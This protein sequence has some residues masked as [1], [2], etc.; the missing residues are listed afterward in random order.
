MTN[1][2]LPK[3]RPQDN[4]QLAATPPQEDEFAFCSLIGRSHLLAMAF[5]QSADFYDRYL[6]LRDVSPQEL[7][8]WKSALVWLLKKLS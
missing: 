8:Q 5:P 4:V 1:L 2:F 7:E 6:T 3:K